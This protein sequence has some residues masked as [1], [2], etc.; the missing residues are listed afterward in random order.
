MLSSARSSLASLLLFFAA[1]KGTKDQP[2]GVSIFLATLF[3]TGAVCVFW[4]AA[5][6]SE[7]GVVDMIGG[8]NGP[9]S[10]NRANSPE[11]FWMCVSIYALSGLGCLGGVVY[12][13]RNLIRKLKMSGGISSR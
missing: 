3:L 2:L 10:V 8:R 4:T 12:Q 13:V 5:T 11:I 6:A 9:S 7:T 1:M